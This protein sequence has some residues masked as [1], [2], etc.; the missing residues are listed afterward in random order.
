MKRKISPFLLIFF[1][2]VSGCVRLSSQVETPTALPP[3]FPT[4]TPLAPAPSSLTV[5]LGE[6]PNTLYPFGELN[7]S[8]RSVL[9]AINDGPFDTI[10]YD[11]QAVILTQMP[12]LE[13]EEAQI[14]KIRVQA[15]SRFARETL[16]QHPL[17]GRNFQHRQPA[18]LHA[19]DLRPGFWA[20]RHPADG[21]DSNQQRHGAGV[22]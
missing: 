6:E 1:I 21:H 13:N 9:A 20:Q 17:H 4:I 19:L 15:G 5:C 18:R 12:A 10:S 2:L 11:Y 3:L 8:A 14:A 22:Q 16:S 7:A